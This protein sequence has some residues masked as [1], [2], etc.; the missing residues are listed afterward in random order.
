[1]SPS[2]DLVACVILDCHGAILVMNRCLTFS[3]FNKQSH[4]EEWNTPDISCWKQEVKHVKVFDWLLTQKDPGFQLRVMQHAVQASRFQGLQLFHLF[5]QWQWLVR[6]TL[7]GSLHVYKYR[8]VE[9]FLY[10]KVQLE[11]KK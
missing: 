1:M 4:I 11:Q 5:S 8:P 9:V 7:K 3:V 6:I 10:D 2:S